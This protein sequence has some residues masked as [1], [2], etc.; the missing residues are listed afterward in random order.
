[1]KTTVPRI[2]LACLL[3]AAAESSTFAGYASGEPVTKIAADSIFIH[4]QAVSKAHKILLYPDANQKAVFFSVKGEEGRAYQ[5]FIFDLEGRLVKQTEIRNR[6]T[7]VITEIEKGV[8]LFDVFSD[9]MKIGNGQ[10][11]VR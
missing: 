8:Y 7:T 2:L 1:M 10:M 5:L 9:D 3:L 11:T 6:Q 4:K